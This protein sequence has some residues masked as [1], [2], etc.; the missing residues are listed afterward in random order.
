MK[1]LNLL[2]LVGCVSNSAKVDRKS[3]SSVDIAVKSI[4]YSIPSDAIPK[5]FFAKDDSNTEDWNSLAY[6]MRYPK[7]KK[8]VSS[9]NLSFI[10]KN[11]NSTT[12][13]LDN[14]MRKLSDFTENDYSRDIF[15]FFNKQGE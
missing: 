15:I 14:I 6:A 4:R 5:I 3:A 2:L 12:K 8:A 13:P 10:D 1:I 11:N 9:Y 7:L